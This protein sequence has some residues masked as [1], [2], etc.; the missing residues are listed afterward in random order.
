MSSVW[1]VDPIWG[2]RQMNNYLSDLA[3]LE[4]GA[5][6][7]D[8]ADK[9]K[10]APMEPTYI[11]SQGVPTQAASE[12]AQIYVNG[13]MAVDGQMGACG[14]GR[15]MKQFAEDL[16]ALEHNSSVKGVLLEINSGGGEA[17]A[18][19][20]SAEAIKNFSK[21]VVAYG[22]F[23]GSAAY[24]LASA[25]DEIVGAGTGSSF[26]SIGTM[27]Q[28]SNEG[29]KML[30][31]EVTTIYSTLSSSKNK[32][33]RGLLAGDNSAMLETLDALAN[34]FISEVKSHRDITNKE[35]F[36]GGMYM[37]KDAKKYGLVDNIGTK[38]KALKILNRQIKLR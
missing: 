23:V 6:L 2:L 32:E 12:I 35:V 17:T 1:M 22:H 26:G 27:I 7:R 4:A 29:L 13:L 8:I 15:G 11:T 18:G 21:P 31:E 33:L 14:R 28:I 3:L 24:M 10:A 37:A 19:H 9:Y 38:G 30:A 25:T 5:S 36:T 20:L 34:N 16:E